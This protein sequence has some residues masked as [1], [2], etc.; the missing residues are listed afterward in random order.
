MG[1]SFVFFVSII[2]AGLYTKILGAADRAG[3]CP[4]DTLVQRSTGVVILVKS[5]Y[6]Q[7]NTLVFHRI[8]FH[9]RY[10]R[11]DCIVDGR[12]APIGVEVSGESPFDNAPW[13]CA[14]RRDLAAMQSHA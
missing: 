12:E 5:L 1:K 6:S 4:R 11:I 10:S 2:L 8:I 14:G 9:R 7:T 13:N 3:R